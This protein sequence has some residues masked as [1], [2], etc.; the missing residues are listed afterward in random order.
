M[1]MMAMFFFITHKKGFKYHA[2]PET[3]AYSCSVLKPCS[4]KDFKNSI[5]IKQTGESF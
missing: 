2:Q 4:F 5:L 1:K 3:G